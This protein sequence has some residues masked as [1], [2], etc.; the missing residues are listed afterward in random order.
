MDR[1]QS[2][3]KEGETLVQ[4]FQ[5]LVESLDSDNND[6]NSEDI[7]DITITAGPSD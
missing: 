1:L 5:K 7:K 6:D 4:S 2:K 3:S